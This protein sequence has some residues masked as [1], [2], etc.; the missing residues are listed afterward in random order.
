MVKI[1][2][3]ELPLIREAILI[4][5]GWKR[6]PTPMRNDSLLI[7]HFGAERAARLGPIIKSLEGDFYASN[8]KFTAPNLQEMGKIASEEF[9]KSY[10]EMPDDAIEALAWCYTYDYK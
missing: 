1:N 6:N 7:N 10:P 5:T 4:W 8:A 3:S 2:S 9:R